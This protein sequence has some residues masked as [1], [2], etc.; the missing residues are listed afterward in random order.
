MQEY[1]SSILQELWFIASQLGAVTP[2]K[3]LKD[4][5]HFRNYRTNNIVKKSGLQRSNE[6]GNYRIPRTVLCGVTILDQ[7][8]SSTIF[9]V[10]QILQL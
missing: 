5:L 8:T 9:K 10:R 7:T 1:R 3:I 6:R 4:G 2:I